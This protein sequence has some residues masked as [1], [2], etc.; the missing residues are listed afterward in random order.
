MNEPSAEHEISTNETLTM[1]E[2]M[3]RRL[4]NK[5]Y[6]DHL[7]DAVVMKDDKPFFTQEKGTR[8]IIERVATVLSGSPWLDT[9]SY[10]VQSVDQETGVLKLQD[11]E[12]RHASESNFITATAAGYRFKKPPGKGAPLPTKNKAAPKPAVTEAPTKPSKVASVSSKE[13][14][15]RVYSSRGIIHT[16]IKGIAYVPSST[17]Q[18]VDGM[19]LMMSLTSGGLKVRSVDGWEENWVPSK[20]M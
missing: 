4:A 10:I 1:Q 8:V 9:R 19:R 14:E 17:T 6:I 7:E 20:D 16:R 5:P 11:E 2:R 18:A 15:R 12:M 3:K 13:S